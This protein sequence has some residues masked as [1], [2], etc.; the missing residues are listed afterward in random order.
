VEQETN[1]FFGVA[2]L[3]VIIVFGLF[4]FVLLPLG[5]LLTLSA[6][7]RCSRCLQRMGEKQFIG[8]PEDFRAPVW[9]FRLGKCSIVTARVYAV[10]TAIL[11]A[12]M[13]G[14]Y[15]YMRPSYTFHEGPL[16]THNEDRHRISTSWADYLKDCGGEKVIENS[17]HT[18]IVWNENYENNI[19]EWQGYFADIKYRNRGFL[20]S[21]IEPNILVKMEP[22]ESTMFADLVLTVPES[23][24]KDNKEMIDAL[25]KG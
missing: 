17:V 14:Y 13:S 10:I 23:I 12:A 20:F 11:L 18:K 3:L 5:Y 19:V 25:K 16:T 24:Y 1:P 8:L 2:S 15:V 4:S 6:V 9:H 21:H 7:H 22:S